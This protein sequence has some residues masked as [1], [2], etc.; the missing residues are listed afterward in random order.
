MQTQRI[1]SVIVFFQMVSVAYAT[2]LEP[3]VPVR[4]CSG[5]TTYCC[6]RY[7]DAVADA[8]G[9]VLYAVCN[10]R[11]ALPLGTTAGKVKEVFPLD[12]SL[13]YYHIVQ[14]AGID[15]GD[16]IIC[17]FSESHPA[18]Q[19]FFDAKTLRCF[20]IGFHVDFE[21]P[22]EGDL[23]RVFE[24]NGLQNKEL[25]KSLS[26]SIK[27]IGMD[28]GNENVGFWFNH[29]TREICV[30]DPKRLEYTAINIDDST[31]MTGTIIDGI[32]I[33]LR[34][35]CARSDIIRFINKWPETVTATV[36]SKLLNERTGFSIWDRV[37]LAHIATIAGDA[38]SELILAE[39]FDCEDI[40]IREWVRNAI[41][42]L[43]T[44]RNEMQK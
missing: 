29:V 24:K 12:G 28:I 13:K 37:R 18:R 4:K 44:R 16:D 15:A 17:T 39:Y 41:S 2:T 42:E 26:D 34:S 3:I 25:A 10:A 36:I 19:W 30:A 22:I 33:G 5:P 14:N 23:I 8:D 27:R 32:R 40:E 38:N 9:P 1:S 35:D 6:V 11:R 7:A 20:L 43:S 31:A 21:L